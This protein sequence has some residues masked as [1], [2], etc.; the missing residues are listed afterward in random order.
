M[1]VRKIVVLLV[2]VTQFGCPQRKP[3]RIPILPP[4][5]SI[6]ARVPAMPQFRVPAI[7]AVSVPDEQV[8]SFAK[9]ITPTVPYQINTELDYLVAELFIQHV[10]SSESK[11][12]VRW[13]GHNPAA[14]SLDDHTYYLGGID[15]FPDGGTRILRLLHEYDR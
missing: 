5:V 2:L 9:L 15:E 13:T 1:S 3:E 8:S 4:I 12:F 10:D 7:E 14:V 11:L 6:T